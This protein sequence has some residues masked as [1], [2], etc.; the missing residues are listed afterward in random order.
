MS[1]FSKKQPETP[2]RRQS[3]ASGAS[4]RPTES[5]LEQRY[6]FR[7][8]RTLTGSASSNVVSTNESNA[9]LKSSRVHMHDLAR[10]RRHI[11]FILTVVLLAT[12]VLFSLVIQFT[13]NV[14]VR[15]S[16]VSRTLEPVY[17]EAIES[18]LA[19]QPI[20]RLRFLL[21]EDSLNEYL[22]VVTPEIA[23][24]KVDGFAGFGKSLFVVEMRQPIAGWNIRGVQRYVDASG[25]SFERNHDITPKV[26]IVDNSGIQVEA[27]QAVAS[28]QFLGFVGR[29]VG[30]ANANHHPVTQV[31]IPQG[32]TRQIE[33]RIQDIAFPIKLSIDRPAGEQIEDMTRSL[34]WLQSRSLAP[35]YLDVRVSGRAFYR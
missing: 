5:D 13:A 34:A 24:V 26:Q 22:Q 14:I 2:R 30:L 11:G 21:H 32:T 23:S 15:T 27:G 33:L 31:I 3:A 10:Q 6:A 9:Q 7:R 1:L 25:A 19:R 17:A 35:E 18:Y 28:N 12:A 20:E 29:V 4:A 8:N 16:D